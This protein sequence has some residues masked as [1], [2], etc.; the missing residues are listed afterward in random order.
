MNIFV[1]FCDSKTIEFNIS[2]DTDIN[3]F[4]KNI[5]EFVSV[6]LN[7]IIKLFKGTL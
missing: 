7:H 3:D 6:E 5:S 4:I 1:K 2:Y